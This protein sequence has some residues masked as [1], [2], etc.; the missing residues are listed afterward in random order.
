MQPAALRVG[1]DCPP[2]PQSW[3]K[4]GEVWDGGFVYTD[5]RPHS[6]QL[7]PVA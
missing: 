1:L 5:V 7:Y 6:E 2:A 3:M 4:V